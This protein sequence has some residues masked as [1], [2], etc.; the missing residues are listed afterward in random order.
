VVLYRQHA[1]RSDCFT[2]PVQIPRAS[3]LLFCTD[4]TATASTST[5]RRGGCRSQ[6]LHAGQVRNQLLHLIALEVPTPPTSFG[7]TSTTT[8]SSS[9]SSSSSSGRADHIWAFNS[10]GK[11]KKTP[12]LACWCT[13]T[14]SRSTCKVRCSATGRC[15]SSGRRRRRARKG[16]RHSS[17][18]MHCSDLRGGEEHR[19][20][21]VAPRTQWVG[22]ALRVGRVA[23]R[24]EQQLELVQRAAELLVQLDGPVLRQGVGLL[25]GR[26]VQPLQITIQ[27]CKRSNTQYN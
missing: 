26:A 19:G 22:L 9:S 15:S 14:F 18:G 17:G 4:R 21:V 7:T 3:L 5:S 16:K 11:R 27:L 1:H 13:S 25:A 12:F 6:Q 24:E 10:R 8:S 20:L 23:Q 2:V